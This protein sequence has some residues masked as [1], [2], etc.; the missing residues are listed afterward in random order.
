[1]VNGIILHPKINAMAKKLDKVVELNAIQWDCL[2]VKTFWRKN[3][4]HEKEKQRKN[5]DFIFTPPEVAFSTFFDRHKSTYRWIYGI[6][7]NEEKT[8][9][10]KK[11]NVQPVGN[12]DEYCS[13]KQKKL[14]HVKKIL[15]HKKENHR[16][17]KYK[18]WSKIYSFWFY[19][20]LVHSAQQSCPVMLDEFQLQRFC[21]C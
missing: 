15:C 3:K 5:N 17:S 4:K 14:K 13:Q 9:I 16:I 21:L 18:C 2:K 10:R 8:W 20:S 7:W 6:G 1:M 12:S 19:F 11:E